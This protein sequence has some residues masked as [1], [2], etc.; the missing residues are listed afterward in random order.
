ME[1]QTT[2]QTVTFIDANG[3]KANIKIEVRAK[4]RLSISGDNGQE[5]DTIKPRTESQTR[6]IEIWNEHHLNQ[7]PEG[8]QEEI[9]GL[10]ELI[11]QEEE[12]RKGEP[13]QYNDDDNTLIE[14]IEENTMFTGDDAN[15]CAALVKM[16]DLT[17]NDL[18]DVEIDSNNRVTVQ[19]IE[20]L[21]GTD[22]E[23]DEA[24]DEDLE[25]YIDECILPDLP[26]TAR[27]YF[28]NEAWKR[29]ARHD[30]RAHSLNRY[31][32]SEEEADVNGT[33]YFAYRQ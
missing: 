11:E 9:D 8:L 31:D 4:N 32:G 3:R 13:I 5:Q 17:I 33:S 27:R 7:M 24:W 10:I 26:E 18:D 15:L 12:S 20:Y 22:R 14:I 23:M 1:N 2:T 19:G 28:D 16:F 29:D 6:L 25:N 30:G 21:A